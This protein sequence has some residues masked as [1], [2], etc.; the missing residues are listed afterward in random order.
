MQTL[1]KLKK[2][3]HN[4]LKRIYRAESLGK[5]KNFIPLCPLDDKRPGAEHIFFPFI[6]QETIQTL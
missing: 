1:A 2:P 5:Y 3:L 6:L 4:E